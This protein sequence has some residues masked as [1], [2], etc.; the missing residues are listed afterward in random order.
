MQRDL[1]VIYLVDRGDRSHLLGKPLPEAAGTDPL[2]P[3]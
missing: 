3:S 1:H 2:L